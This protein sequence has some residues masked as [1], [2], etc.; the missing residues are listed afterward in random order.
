MNASAAGSKAVD[1]FSGYGAAQAALRSFT[2]FWAAELKHRKI[3]VNAI[4]P[5]PIA[6]P[7]LEGL[8]VCGLTQSEKQIEQV[9]P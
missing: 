8:F 1:G 3:R 4:S 5:G 2:R 9:D 6:T 7:D